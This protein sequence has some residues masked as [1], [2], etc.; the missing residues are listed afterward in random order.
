M[1]KLS[2]VFNTFKIPKNLSSMLEKNTSKLYNPQSSG[3]AR[4]TLSVINE[5]LDFTKNP[6]PISVPEIKKKLL[7][8]FINLTTKDGKPKYC[9]LEINHIA[10]VITKENSDYIK[11]LSEITIDGKSLFDIF[12]IC[13]LIKAI[14]T[15]P[16]VKDFTDKIIQLAKDGDLRFAGYNS[17]KSY[18]TKQN[19][20]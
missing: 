20:D 12:S 11:H 10:E 15:N 5:I 3:A 16:E 9:D 19:S 7:E 18:I 14:N 8:P 1:F 4:H 2:I 13:K 6:K 17:R